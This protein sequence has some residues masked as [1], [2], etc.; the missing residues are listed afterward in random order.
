ME[1]RTLARSVLSGAKRCAKYFLL[2]VLVLTIATT[3][4]IWVS[5]DDQFAYSPPRTL[6]NDITKMNPT[7]VA[8]VFEPTSVDEVVQAL[9]STTGPVSIG[10]GRFSQGGQVSYPDSVHLDMRKL[11]RIVNLDVE[12][13]RITVGAGATWHQIQEAI[14]PHNLSIRIMQTYSNFTVGG[15]LSVNV[16]GR[17]IGEG[18]VVRSVESIKIVMA[19]GTLVEASPIQNADVFYGAIGGYGGI[20]V[21]V[22]AT[23]SL[24]DDVRIE[25]QRDVM[26]MADY[27]AFFRKNVRDNREIVFHNAD[28]Y[29]PDYTTASVV[30]WH[31]TDKPVTIADR[32]IPAKT[33][34]GWQP[35]ITNWVGRTD[36]GKWAR[37]HVIEPLYYMQDRVV[38]RNWEASYDVAELEPPSR[39]EYTYG[40]REYFIPVEHFDDF[41]PVM[42][43]IFNKHHANIIN[44]S[45]RHALPDPGTLL[46]WA[47]K[48]MF[49]FV[50]YYRQGR[51]AEDIATVRDWSREMIDASTA[52]EG[53]YY[54]PYQVFESPEQF[55][56]AFPRDQEYFALKAKLDPDNRF[57]NRLWQ[58]LY[59]ANRDLLSAKRAANQDYYRSEAQTFLTVPEWYLVFNPVEYANYL[60]AHKNPS[61][62]PFFASIDEYWSI[63]DRVTA[64]SKLDGYPKNSE[65]LTML[66]VIGVSTT[67]EYLLKGSYEGTIGRLT[68]WTAHDTDTSEDELIA[69]AQHAYADFIFN[70]AWYEFD[71]SHWVGKMWSNTPFFGEHFLRKLERRLFFTLEYGVKQGYAKVIGFASH[72][73][74]GIKHDRIYMTVIA[75]ENAVAPEGV[76]VHDQNGR[77][78]LIST[79]RWGPFSE[80]APRLAAAGYTFEDISGNRRIVLSVVGPRDEPLA[81][82]GA[83]ELFAS[84]MVSDTDRVRHVLLAEVG[85]LSSILQAL[86]NSH[87]QFEHIYDY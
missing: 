79:L 34:Y 3:I 62:F 67:V 55:H 20:G 8:Q 33:E 1:R 57:R 13:K 63:Y 44:V 9:K 61:E 19:D 12:H 74:Y 66:R 70:K 22:E 80:A 53:S 83:V 56:A 11:N 81:V 86:P 2:F 15:S 59:P 51:T 17:Y 26:P 27:N 78:Q 39:D 40:L 68:R 64:I 4:T 49:A 47:K 25:R 76:Q 36:T 30:S 7:Y 18:P 45:V 29:P 37:Q 69:Q 60:Q 14:D 52:L 73:A 75:P 87:L 16:H 21:I 5:G 32:I 24:A 71:F 38:W 72:S 10:G 82:K 23:L 6:I 48:E 54:L 35:K 43:D 58:Q 84:R 65:Y 31:T 46:A 28:L 85:Q 77:E 41:V 42:K 50:V